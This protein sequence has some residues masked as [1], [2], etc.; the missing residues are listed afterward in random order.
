MPSPHWNRY[1]WFRLITQTL[2]GFASIPAF[3]IPLTI[4]GE[5]VN[6]AYAGV[7]YVFLMSLS[8][9]TNMFESVIGAGL[10][11]LFES[12]SFGWLVR[13]FEQTPLNI[14][15]K[16]K[17]GGPIIQIYLSHLIQYAQ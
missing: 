11:K 7:S 14:A 16:I 4:A 2:L 9:V 12:P 3:I 6:T 17:I 5:T 8:N 13:A 1:Q 15:H 10:Y